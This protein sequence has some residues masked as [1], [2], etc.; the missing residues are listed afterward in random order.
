MKCKNTV[1][2]E[3][4]E[5]KEKISKIVYR[6]QM[7]SIRVRITLTLTSSSRLDVRKEWNFFFF[8]LGLHSLHMEVPRLGVESEL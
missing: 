2:F 1:R 3:Y 7:I 6:K 5:N 4:T 8:F